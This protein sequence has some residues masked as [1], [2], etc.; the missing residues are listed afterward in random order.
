MERD[1]VDRESV[2][3]RMGNQIPDDLKLEKSD[4]VLDTSVSIEEVG[5]QVKIAFEIL[6]SGTGE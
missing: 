5:E 1:G 2:V 3:A 6:E 4:L